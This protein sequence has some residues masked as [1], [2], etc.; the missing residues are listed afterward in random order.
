M[1]T[2]VVRDHTEPILRKEKHLTVPSVG[3]QRPTV[4]ER[5][6][7]AFAPILVVDF[8]VVFGGDRA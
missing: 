4:R 8:G 5:Y 2:T 1:A 3:V 6:D 7:R